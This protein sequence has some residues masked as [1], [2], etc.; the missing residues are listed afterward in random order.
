MASDRNN[1]IDRLLPGLKHF[2]ELFRWEKR[3]VARFFVTAFGRAAAQMAVVYLIQEFLSNVLGAGQGRVAVFIAAYLGQITLWAVVGLMLTAYL[4]GA[5]LNY[6]NQ[7]VQMR[8][9]KLFEM[10]IMERLVRHLLLLSVPYINS[11]SPG[12]LIQAVRSDVTQLRRVIYA[13]TNIV[14]EGLTAVGL[15]C[16]AFWISPRLAFWSLGVLPLAALPIVLIARGIR[17]KSVAIRTTGYI[18][19][20][21]IVQILSGIRVLKA[22]QAEKREA[23][24]AVEKGNLYFDEG[25]ASVRLRS[26]GQMML[27]S[28]AGLAVVTVIIIGSFQVMDGSLKWPGLFAFLVAAR[29]LHGPIHNMYL[30][31]VEMHGNSASMARI[32]ELF[33]TKPQVDNHPDAVPLKAA[34]QCITFDDVSFSYDEEPVL[35][36]VTFT[37]RAGE[38]IGIVGPS[39]AGK[40][41]LLNLV[42]RFYDPTEGEVLF[43][44]RALDRFRLEDVYAM[45]AVVNQEPFLFATTVRE[46]IRLGRPEAT[47]DDVEEAARA[48]SVH[49]DILSLP[50]GYDT[51]LGIN[52]RTLSRGQAQRINLARAFLKEAPILLL[53]EPTSSLDA[54][55]ES[56]I[57]AAMDELMKGRI[58]FLVTHRF[59]NL[60]AVDRILVLEGGECV[61]LGTH[62]E[63]YRDCPL[64]RDMYEIQRLEESVSCATERRGRILDETTNGVGNLEQPVR[65]AG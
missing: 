32:T 16:V 8:I 30:W 28:I 56:E 13:L 31:F 5:L 54:I 62:A 65:T 25:I 36:S 3:L 52:G 17:A 57:E 7:V 49:D 46:N 44:G 24:I 40:S 63:L 39:G 15:V 58:S 4:G 64:Y 48:A 19:F 35:K 45:V 11:Q 59:S 12:D 53:D 61:G 26:L 60:R 6:D 10:G 38:K 29:A 27:E 50:Q 2:V 55:A 20:D 14:L 41:S 1:G 18:F 23:A 33:E 22:Y 37:V 47:D 21:V 43:D 34:P 42:G 9:I 51:P